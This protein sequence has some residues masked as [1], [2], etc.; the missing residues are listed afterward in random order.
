M[1][2]VRVP[3]PLFG[4]Q[5]QIQKCIEVFI[6]NSRKGNICF[7]LTLEMECYKLNYSQKGIRKNK[8]QK[9]TF[10]QHPDPDQ[11]EEDDENEEMDE[12]PGRV[13]PPPFSP[14]YQQQLW[15]TVNFVRMRKK[16]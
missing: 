14:P 3:L 15:K 1:T 10:C 7:S 5:I 8:K 16:M 2:T 11:E 12:Y 9:R 6:R 4:A 13:T